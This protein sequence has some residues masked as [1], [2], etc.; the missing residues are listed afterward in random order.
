MT[1]SH[2]RWHLWLWLVLGPVVLAGLILSFALRT[3]ALP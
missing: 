2:R 1:R 3:E